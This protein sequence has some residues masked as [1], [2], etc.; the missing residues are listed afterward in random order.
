[1]EAKAS[2]TLVRSTPEL[3]ALADDAERMSAWMGGLTGALG[4]VEVEV[5]TCEPE[6]SLAW[7]SPAS[8]ASTSRTSRC[9]S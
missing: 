1:M 6:R 5:T 3:W 4:P 7:R 2:R 9:S 8:G